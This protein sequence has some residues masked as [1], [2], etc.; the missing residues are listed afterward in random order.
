MPSSTESKL[1]SV[2]QFHNAVTKLFCTYLKADYC[3]LLLC[4]L[5]LYKVCKGTMGGQIIGVLLM[6]G[7]Q[8]KNRILPPEVG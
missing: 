5:N 4:P 6:E 3:A 1:R 2:H 8:V 7:K